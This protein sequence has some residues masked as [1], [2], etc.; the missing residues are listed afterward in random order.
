MV[1]VALFLTV[2]QL[3]KKKVSSHNSNKKLIKD[4]L[5]ANRKELILNICCKHSVNAKWQYSSHVLKMP[6]RSFGL[7][8]LLPVLH[9]KSWFCHLTGCR[10]VKAAERNKTSKMYDTHVTVISISISSVYL[11]PILFS[12]YPGKKLILEEDLGRNLI[13]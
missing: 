13:I 12:P 7:F 9:F 6:L 11:S 4:I 10:A 5:L 2:F 3:A 1:I 8:S